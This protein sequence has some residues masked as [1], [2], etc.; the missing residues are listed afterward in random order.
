MRDDAAAAA[1]RIVEEVLARHGQ[2]VE[3]ATGTVSIP[4]MLNP[5][6]EVDEEPE[7]SARRE[8]SDGEEADHAP[9]GIERPDAGTELLAA[10]GD[11]ASAAAQIARRIVAEALAEAE[12]PSAESSAV[13]REDPQPEVAVHGVPAEGLVVEDEQTVGIEVPN[14]PADADHPT[15]S[16]DTKAADAPSTP[17][18]P[19]ESVPSADAPASGSVEEIVRRIVADVQSEAPTPEAPTPEEW[20][21]AN[22]PVAPDAEPESRWETDTT[23]ML[24]E[25]RPETDTAALPQQQSVAVGAPSEPRSGAAPAPASAAVPSRELEGWATPLRPEP[26]LVTAPVEGAPRTLRWL[27]ASLLGAIALAVLF[28]LAVAALRALVA[29]D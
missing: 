11:A 20:P 4:V 15:D 23:A 28:P 10:A 1:R 2:G 22:G 25:Q 3:P 29:M 13:E 14:D 12:Q 24:E 5:T 17:G 6:G 9:D 27:L 21:A 18:A 7:P 19:P 8:R 26:G 16:D